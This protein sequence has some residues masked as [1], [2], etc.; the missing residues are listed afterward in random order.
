MWWIDV[1]GFFQILS[2]LSCLALTAIVLGH[3][4]RRVNHIAFAALSTNLMLWVLGVF[5]IIHCTNV[6]D[7]RF[8]MRS[9]FIIA[10]LFPGTFYNFVCYSPTGRFQGSRSAV[11][12]FYVVGLALIV[13]CFLPD[14]YYFV[15]VEAKSTGYPN[16]V[17]GPVFNF[18]F[19]PLGVLALILI[20]INLFRKLRVSSGIQRRQIQHVILGVF[21]VAILGFITNML[22]VFLGIR[23]FEPYGPVFVLPTMAIF[24][25]AMIR[26]HLMDVWVILSAT[27]VYTVTTGFVVLIFVGA[28]VLAHYGLSIARGDADIITALLAAIVIAVFLEPLKERLQLIAKRV[29]L[30]RHYDAQQL[31]AR[32]SEKASQ[33]VQIDELMESVCTNIQQTLGVKTIR[34]HLVDPK[35]KD[36]LITEYSS[37]R[38]EMGGRLHQFGMLLDYLHLNPTPLVLEQL[39]HGKPS[40]DRVRI[41]ELLAELDAYMAVPLIQKSTLVGIMTL[42]QKTSKDI[43]TAEDVLAF[44]ALAGPLAAAIENARLYRALEEAN[45]HRARILS[46]MRGGVVAVNTSGEVT[47]VNQGAVEL[48]GPIKIG[49]HVDVLTPEVASVIRQ[50]LTTRQS[51]H[52]YETVITG[53]NGDRISVAMS[54]S[55]LTTVDEEVTGAMALLY[56]LTHLKRL[57]QSMQRAHRLSSI[58][59]LA[60][61][62]AHEIKNPLVS[63][64]T[65]AQLLMDRYNDPDFRNTFSDVVPTEVE[66]IDSIV[67]RLLHFARPK[68]ANFAPQNLHAIIEEVLILL[69]NQIR[70]GIIGVE[71]KLATDCTCIYGDE[72]QLH[73]VF[74][75]LVLNAID[76]MK[77]HGRGTLTIT[78]ARDQASLYSSNG[79]GPKP[80]RECVKVTV[81]DTGTGIAPDALDRIFTPFFTTKDRGSGLG[82]SVVHGIIS[83]HAGQ[84]YV[85]NNPS[86]GASFVILLPL[87]PPPKMRQGWDPNNANASVSSQP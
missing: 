38:R 42:S 72:Q 55:C 29:I 74:L 52:D 13:L 9:T 35:D 56:D 30:K 10:C 54:S 18:G 4:H 58:G 22:L 60:A 50:T 77:D 36:I 83:E 80:V 48:L 68:P 21:V 44:Q 57:E 17:Y 31:L 53:P 76:A 2:A 85:E 25:Y 62:M 69:E 20:Y 28:F 3:N 24:A 33:T 79:H 32:V 46:N 26:Y 7:A 73:Q 27:A 61:G 40:A 1:T 81:S 15:T 34:I 11:I 47:T 75:N 37:D 6:E 65:F 71:T 39:I 5:A 63:I 49:A 19:F 41:A 43:F 16:V 87:D 70:K 67:T 86:G 64:K 45:L 23:F 82:L 51:V 14:P 59:T 78:A 12:F 66:R 84:I 8:W